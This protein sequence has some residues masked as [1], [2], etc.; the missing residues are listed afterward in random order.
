VRQQVA[1]TLEE[2]PFVLGAIGLAIGAAIG[3]ML[4]PTNQED[5]LMGE[6]RDNILEKGKELGANAYEKGRETAV[7][8]VDR[9]SNASKEASPTSTGE[10]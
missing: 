2:Q 5:H 8:A 10:L 1:S 9:I 4:P 6:A 7:E 3:A